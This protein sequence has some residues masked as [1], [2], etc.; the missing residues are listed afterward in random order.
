MTVTVE[1]DVIK[2]TKSS[3]MYKPDARSKKS[4]SIYVG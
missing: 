1:I 3:C 2:I 4:R